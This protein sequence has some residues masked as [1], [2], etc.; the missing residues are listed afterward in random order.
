MKNKLLSIVLSLCLALVSFTTVL[1]VCAAADPVT[2]SLMAPS[3]SDT[4]GFATNAA[5]QV[6]IIKFSAAIRDD[7]ATDVQEYRTFLK[8]SSPEPNKNVLNIDESV[9]DLMK[10]APTFGCY[11]IMM[12]YDN[13][14]NTIIYKLDNR[15]RMFSRTLANTITLDKNFPLLNGQTLG[16]TMVFTF[17]T[18]KGEWEDL[19]APVSTAKVGATATL[20]ATATMSSATA[21]NTSIAKASATQAKAA[22]PSNAKMA[23]LA[24]STDN[25]GISGAILPI[26]IGAVL[27]AGATAAFL[28]IKK[29]KS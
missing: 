22:S 15:I 27:V 29:R 19:S 13:T 23:T 2:V 11:G 12:D 4:T 6:V 7:A 1:P 26:V 28:I 21:T 10:Q 17:N 3:D 9:D 18:T 8:M 25:K 5:D 16:R 24:P 14:D 20:A